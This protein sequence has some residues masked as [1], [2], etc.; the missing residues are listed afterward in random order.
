LDREETKILSELLLSA[1]YNILVFLEG[2]G[3]YDQ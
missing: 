3:L 1:M 2:S